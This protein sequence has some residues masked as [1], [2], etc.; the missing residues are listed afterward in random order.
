MR[1]LFCTDWQNFFRSN[2]AV[3]W[4]MVDLYLWWQHSSALYIW[5]CCFEAL[6]S[7]IWG[8]SATMANRIKGLVSKNKRRFREDGFDLDLTCIFLLSVLAVALGMVWVGWSVVSVSLSVCIS[9]CPRSKMK[10]AS[11]W[12]KDTKVSREI[13]CVRP[14]ACIALTM[15]WGQ[16]IKESQNHQV[17]TVCL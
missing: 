12:A 1:G 2:R 8:S 14:S 16:Q 11:A 13:I 5:F 7:N 4:Y 9:V 6:S 15:S 10:M 3:V 17:Q